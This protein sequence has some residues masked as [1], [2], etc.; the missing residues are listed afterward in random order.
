[1]AIRVPGARRDQRDARAQR[2][3]QGLRRGRPAPV[4]GDLEDLRPREAPF[5][6]DRLDLL[7]EVTREEH[8][9]AADLAEQHD[10]HVIDAGPIVRRFRGHGFTVGPEDCEPHAVHRQRV[11]GGEATARDAVHRQRE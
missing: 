1:M 10:R 2:V 9:L 5:E 11:A 3:D 4:V 8:V 7:F 6:E